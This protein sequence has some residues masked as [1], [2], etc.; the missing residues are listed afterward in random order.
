MAAGQTMPG[1]RPLKAEEIRKHASCAP[2]SPYQ[3]CQACQRS[4]GQA[5]RRRFWDEALVDE[6]PLDDDRSPGT[7]V[8]NVNAHLRRAEGNGVGDRWNH[9]AAVVISLAGASVM[10]NMGLI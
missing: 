7:V 9:G 10:G 4:G 3:S 5:G 2:A 8:L 1:R 6:L